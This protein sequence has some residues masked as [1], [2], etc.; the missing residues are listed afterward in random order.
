MA[1]KEDSWE[2]GGSWGWRGPRGVPGDTQES[3]PA[4]ALK[5][6]TQDPRMP[7][8][9]YAQQQHQSLRQPG[10]PTG[11]VSMGEEAGR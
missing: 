3:A 4:I 7:G 5:I 11:C 9:T 2:R 1:P 8:E 10:M 6:H